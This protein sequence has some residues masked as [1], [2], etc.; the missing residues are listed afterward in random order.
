[1]NYYLIQYRDKKEVLVVTAYNT[2]DLLRRFPTERCRHYCYPSGAIVVY[3][4][5]NDA[6][7]W[8]TYLNKGFKLLE[9]EFK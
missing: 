8:A 5:Q 1:M 2:A 9:K 3:E 4:D 6:E 7:V